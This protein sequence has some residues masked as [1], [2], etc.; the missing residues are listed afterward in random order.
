MKDSEMDIYHLKTIKLNPDGYIPYNSV[1]R[2]DLGTRLRFVIE[3][4]TPAS[5]LPFYIN[6]PENPKEKGFVR[7]N[8]RRL[9]PLQNDDGGDTLN[10]DVCYEI[11]CDS[12]GAFQYFFEKKQHGML[13]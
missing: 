12:P 10:W 2:I 9:Y 3:N 4:G 6:Y 7:N 11:Q 5:L 8:F 13:P 1:T